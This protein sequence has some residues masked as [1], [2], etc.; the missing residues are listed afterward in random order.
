MN[1]SVDRTVCCGFGNCVEACPEVFAF[2]DADN[3]ARVRERRLPVRLLGAVLRVARD[4]PT[5]AIAVHD[6]E[7]VPRCGS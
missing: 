7:E 6:P 2:D 1:V 5:A 3:R 4:C